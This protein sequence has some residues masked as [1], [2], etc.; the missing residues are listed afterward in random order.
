MF[1]RLRHE[2]EPKCKSD[3]L[4]WDAM[5][6]AEIQRNCCLGLLGNRDIEGKLEQL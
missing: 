6:E 2:G 1:L 5:K 3:K 4:S